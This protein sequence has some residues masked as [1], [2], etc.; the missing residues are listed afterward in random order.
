MAKSKVTSTSLQ[1]RRYC[2]VMKYAETVDRGHRCNGVAST[3]PAMNI[4]EMN[5]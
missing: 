5:F 2:K 1:M 3:E 4:C